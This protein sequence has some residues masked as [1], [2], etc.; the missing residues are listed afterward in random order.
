MPEVLATGHGGDASC[1][2]SSRD[3]FPKKKKKE[4]GDRHPLARQIV[5]TFQQFE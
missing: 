2:D 3:L 1:K 5:I 4:R